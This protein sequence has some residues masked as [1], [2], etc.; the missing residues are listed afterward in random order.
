M[1]YLEIYLEVRFYKLI[2]VPEIQVLSVSHVPKCR[3]IQVPLMFLEY[4]AVY[5][6]PIN[7][8]EDVASDVI[9]F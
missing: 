5:M 6:T 1:K 7:P 8:L 4:P 9:S 2:N 3:S